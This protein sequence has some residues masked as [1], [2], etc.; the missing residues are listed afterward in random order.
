MGGIGKQLR[1]A[2]TLAYYS[3]ADACCRSSSATTAVKA[4]EM[5]ARGRAILVLVER[6]ESRTRL[7]GCG[8]GR[9]KSDKCGGRG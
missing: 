1:H 8:T 3:R 7:Q 2:C 9:W 5:G 4:V 6:R